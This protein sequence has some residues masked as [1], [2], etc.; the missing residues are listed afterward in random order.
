MWQSHHRRAEWAHAYDLSGLRGRSLLYAG[1]AETWLKAPGAIEGFRPN[2]EASGS[3]VPLLEGLDHPEGMR[4]R[5]QMEP[6][7]RT[8]SMRFLWP[9]SENSDPTRSSRN[10]VRAEP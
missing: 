10:V 5:A 6:W 3:R 1:T 4:A 7:V 9:S 8:L 2:V